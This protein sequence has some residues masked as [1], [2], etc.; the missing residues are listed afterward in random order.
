VAESSPTFL[1]SA[2]LALAIRRAKA[3]RADLSLPASDP[4]AIVGIGCRF[5]GDVRSADDY[6]RLLHN[7]VDA[8]TTIPPERWDADAYF[9][10]DPQAPGKTNSRYGGFIP[11]VDMF[12]PLL[13]GIAP[14]EAISMDPQQRLLLEVVWE[15]I[16]N[17]GCAP[18]SLAGSLAGVFIAVYNSDYSRLLVENCEAIGPNTTAGGS[19]SIASGRISFLLDL[20]GPCLSIDTACSSSLVA[21]H[22]A[23]QS[24]RAGECNIA[25]AGGITLHLLPEHYIA[26]AKLG[27]LAPDGRCK[28]FDSKADGFVPG[29]GCGI[30]V[31]KP[32]A[33]ALKNGDHIYAVIRGTAVNQDGRTN[34][35]TAPNGL[36]QREVIRAALRNAQVPASC[37]SYVEAHGT[38]TALGDPIEVE[39]LAEILGAESPTAV[40]CAL[41]AV[42]S[43]L[44]H[45]EAAAGVAG[46]IKAALALDR[47]EIPPNLHYNELNPHITLQGT[48]FYLPA[49]P[50]PWP[51]GTQP[52]FASTS[53][54]GFG[55][56]NAHVV[57]EEAPQVP[58]RHMENNAAGRGNFLLPISARTPEALK[59]FARLYREFL[60]SESGKRIELYDICHSAA[61]RRH[62][63]EERLTVQGS[64]HQELSQ[65]L[66]D[67]LDGRTPAG[68]AVGRSSQESEGIAFLFSG[69]GSQWPRMGA[70]LYESEPA[71]R[72]AIEECESLVRRY[73]GWSLVE[74]LLAPAENSQLDHTE[75]AQPAI[76]CVEVALARLWESWG[77]A[78]AVVIGHSAG[79]VAAAHVAGVLGLDEAV[80]VVVHRG[81]LME[82][83]TGLGKMAAIHL[84][85]S[86]VSERIK[87]FSESISIAALN[88]PESTVISGDPQLVER[89]TADWLREGVGCRM[90]PV[91]YAF[92]SMQMDPYSA[93]LPRLLESVAIS[94]QSVPMI[95]TVTGTITDGNQFHAEY[96]GQNVRLPVLFA[97][98]VEA[99]KDL[100][101]QTFLEIGPH[102]VLLSNVRDCLEKSERPQNLI[103]SLHRNKNEAAAMLSSLGRFYALGYSVKWESLYSRQAPPVSLPDYP[104]QRQ[105]YWISRRPKAQANALHPLL[106]TQLRSPLIHGAAFQSELDVSVLPYLADHRIDGSILLPMTAFLET[107]SNAVDI[108]SGAPRAIADIVIHSPLVLPEE[109]GRTVQTTVEGNRFQVFSADGEGWKLHASGRSAEMPAMTPVNKVRFSTKPAAGLSPID[110]SLFYERLAETGLEFGTSFCVLQSLHAG[111]N[112]SLGRICLSE[113]EARESSHY[114]M[115]PALL[116]GC[117]QTTLAAAARDFNEI[118][119]PFSMERFEIFR[120]AGAQVW[121]HARIR[122]SS[123]NGE[124]LSTD[125]DI[126]DEHGELLARVAA[127]H[128]KRRTSR[129]S[130]ERKMYQ[131]QW[132]QSGHAASEAAETGSCLV[133]CEDF[134][135]GQKLADSLQGREIHATLRK[136]GGALDGAMDVQC[137][138]Q[139]I[140]GG[141]AE[142]SE[143]IESA[144][145]ASVLRLVRELLS[146][147]P[148]RPPRLCLITRGAVAIGPSD[149]CEGFAQAPI[150]GMARTIAMEHPELRCRTL[151][152]DPA[153]PDFAALAEEIGRVSPEDQTV[154]RGN[155]KY[156]PRLE[157]KFY[158]PI[159]PRRLSVSARGSIDNLQ[160]EIL[161]RRA[162]SDREVEV[163]VETTALNFR[164]VLGVLGMYPGDPGPLGL[165]FCGRIARVGNGLTNYAPGDRVMGIAWGSFASFVNTPAALI[166]PVPANLNT[167]QAAGISNAFLT[168]YHCLVEVAGL[169]Q[170][171]KVLI[172]AATGGVGLAAVQIA[173]SAGVEIFATAGSEE[174]REYLRKLQVPH[175]FSSRTLDFAREIPKIAGGK[176]V[177]VVLNSLAGDFLAASFA[178]T[179]DGGRFIEIGKNDVWTRERVAALSKSI[180]YAIVDLAPVIDGEPERI[181]SYFSKIRENL[182]RGVFRPLPISVFE[183]DHCAAAFRYMAEAKHIGKV[184]VRHPI[185]TRIA[186][187]ATYLVTGG[188]GAIG[189]LTAEWLVSRGARNL[190][191][192]GRSSPDSHA[193][194]K[195]DGMRQAGARVEIRQADVSK[196]ADLALILGEIGES[197]PPLRGVIHAAGVVDD[198][199]LAQQTEE[200]FER[201]MAPKVAGA[202]NLHELT[203]SMPLDFLVMFSSVASIT[204]SPSQSAY[205][206]GN[207]FLDALAQYRRNFGL[208]TLSVNWGAWA[209]AGMAARVAAQGGRHALSAIRPMPPQDCFDCLETA[210]AAGAS[211]VV[212]ADIDWTQW[213]NPSPLLSD[214]VKKVIPQNARIPQDS[215]LDVLESAPQ[216]NRRKLLVDYLRAEALGILGL[217]QSYFIDER[218]PLLKMGLDSL[219]AVDFRNRLSAALRRNLTATL[220]FDYPTIGE[221]ADFLDARE[222]SSPPESSDPLLRA[223][224]GVSDAEAE[225]LLKQELGLTS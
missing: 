55:G 224:D 206:A 129:S 86:Q 18:E 225:E 186:A 80:R 61:T 94:K 183:F 204:G 67:F 105:R 123:S 78:P 33:D 39:A 222:P 200:R 93:E 131:V 208:P 108:L 165:E 79:E 57:I 99:A 101:L 92:H 168:A 194:A 48:R 137:V 1:S 54:F 88:S 38:G 163:E 15:A 106:G 56:T 16:W 75:F 84:P 31:L 2:K 154:F 113:R 119:L 117:L 179:A 85:A 4:I 110:L 73:A 157:P 146:R 156:H 12:D 32:L 195:V 172:H 104:Y 133:I 215:I 9:D 171:D 128:L 205:A 40:P 139:I 107:A 90:L 158:A 81:R 148:T 50:T 112:E 191:L 196:R 221:L 42:K 68:L 201:V 70:S 65:L 144:A 58:Q 37:V 153:N 197:M 175:V 66:C 46:L 103:P 24:L 69:Q 11:K 170:G 5:P 20:H 121:A 6:W 130:I 202:W 41:G 150:W 89:L 53:S 134:V 211:Q 62:H 91:N 180:H 185:A 213:K 210:M 13:F 189:L 83:A 198:G 22:V 203:R 100:R 76:F 187:D 25:L 209:D 190:L 51:R 219:M 152:L 223:M 45:L 52:R 214:L 115:H 8:I 220:L 122:P 140:E 159:E 124:T 193:L 218:Q 19:H 173:Q 177:D 162:P 141:S 212:V 143:K 27:M 149:R 98:A 23:C 192:L 44:G 135:D 169:K 60:D 72:A 29:E 7:G 207:A 132:R 182:A 116:D 178:V 35:L 166:T 34:V 126:F 142:K 164:D 114:R 63:H 216:A 138:A 111:E 21:I 77:V 26:M 3:E 17:S 96:W 155:K 97:A 59:D 188:L 49:Q 14:R 64:T 217:N 145:C 181:R 160:T 43:N 74:Q 28:T 127:L 167:A 161:V 174:K 184:V 125:I 120:P 82:R 95:S 30:V 151:D 176:G 199:I 10:A 71:F 102:P 47:E 147:F 87:A 36:A 109:G 136:P 118:Y